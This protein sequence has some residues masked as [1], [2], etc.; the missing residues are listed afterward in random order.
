MNAQLIAERIPN[1][2]PVTFESAGHGLPLQEPE[3]V[4]ALV[5]GF[6]N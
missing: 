6:L 5:N 1:A 3:L 2:V 4:A